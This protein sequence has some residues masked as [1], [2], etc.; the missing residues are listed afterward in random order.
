MFR[1]VQEVSMILLDKAARAAYD[2]VVAAKAAKKAFF[3]Q[4]RTT[5]DS[6]RRKFRED[7]E[8]REAARSHEASAS[9]E[10]DFSR[11]RKESARLMAEEMERRRRQIEEDEKEQRRR[12]TQPAPSMDRPAASGEPSKKKARVRTP[13]NDLEPKG[14]A[15]GTTAEEFDA[16]EADILEKMRTSGRR[17]ADDSQVKKEVQ[18]HYLI[19]KWSPANWRRGERR[20]N[21]RDARSTK[22]K[23]P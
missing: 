19:R 6:K 20:R 8:R 15:H 10:R 2:H 5:E 11:L 17:P 18:E 9:Q 13:R 23:C 7:L 16:F 12:R 3:E 4:R 14:F 21:D 1:K 22:G